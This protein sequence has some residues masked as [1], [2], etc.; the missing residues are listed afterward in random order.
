MKNYNLV[1]VEGCLTRDP[2]M[3]YSE[4][5]T[6]I[7]KFSIAN[8]YDSVDKSGKKSQDVSYFDVTS[9]G[10]LAEIFGKY[11]TKGKRIIV[12]GK[13]RQYRWSDGDKKKSKIKILAENIDFV[14]HN[15]FKGYSKS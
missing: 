2:E 6:P 15:R 8:N 7:L 3:S 1:V 10:N 11:L 4:K 14:S 13:M 12:T 5:N 9:V